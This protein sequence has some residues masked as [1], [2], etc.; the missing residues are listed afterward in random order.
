MCVCVCVLIAVLGLTFSPHWNDPSALCCSEGVLLELQ[1]RSGFPE[2]L[3]ALLLLL[4]KCPLSVLGKSTMALKCSL[5]SHYCSEMS[6]WRSVH[7]H[8]N[9]LVTHSR[10]CSDR[11]LLGVSGTFNPHQMSPLSSLLPRVFPPAS[12]LVKG[13]SVSGYLRL[14]SALC[15]HLVGIVVWLSGCLPSTVVSNSSARQP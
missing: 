14:I 5:Y 13:S 6:V 7:L 12:D 8:R 15:R 4:W 11:A 10:Y 1:T 9:A 2:R 3:P